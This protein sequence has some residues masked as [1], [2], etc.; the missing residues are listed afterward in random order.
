MMKNI[1]ASMKTIETPRPCSRV[2][3]KTPPP[4]APRPAK[5]SNHDKPPGPCLHGEADADIV[6]GA[7][8]GYDHLLP[9]T[10]LFSEM[11]MC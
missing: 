11:K 8:D 3:D 2:Q 4:D 7:I 9:L 10:Q 6:S 5:D 1:S